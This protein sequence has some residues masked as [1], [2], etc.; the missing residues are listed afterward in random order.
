[1]TRFT[2]IRT[3]QQ[4]SLRVATVTAERLFKHMTNGRKPTPHEVYPDA[5]LQ[6]DS[7]GRLALR[8]H[9]GIAVLTV[10]G[11]TTA[12]LQEATKQAAMTLPTTV[13]AFAGAD[14]QSVVILVCYAVKEQQPADESV[15]TLLASAAYEQAVVTYSKAVGHPIR[16][17]T[18]TVRA[19]FTR[20][21][22]PTA[23]YNP[24]AIPLDISRYG[25]DTMRI[26]DLL[27]TRYRFRYNTVMG[28]TEYRLK[29]DSSDRW[30]PVD[31]RVLKSLTMAARLSGVDAW[32]NDIR[33]YVESSLIQ[34]YNPVQ[35]FLQRAKSCWD[36][37]TDHIGRLAATVPCELTQWPQ[38]FRKWLL[39]M[40]AQWLGKTRRYGNSVAPLLISGQG[41]NKSTFCR[42][43]LPEC[44]Q[45]GYN[46]NLL[47]SE[48]KQTLQAM[49]QFLLI[50]L[51]EFNQISQQM[52][53]GF[54]K[55]VIQLARVKI[56]R[57]YGRHV[58]DFPRLASFIATTNELSVLADPS[59][60]RRFIAVELTGPID[61]SQPI[62]YEGLYGQAVTLIERGEQYWFDDQ[63]VRQ[64]IAHNRQF[65]TLS[66]A[67][68]YF[69]E[70][71]TLP[72]DE[73]DGEWL[74]AAAIYDELRRRS[75]NGLRANGLKLFGRVLSNMEGLQ[76]RRVA[77]GTQY[78]VARRLP[79]P[80]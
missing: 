77:Y 30:C 79:M 61:L 70:C 60:N 53:E 69:H 75:G 54:L 55:N 18:A 12:E 43:L 78:F 31:D 21:A 8:R 7:D 41:Y 68:Q 44:L 66:P 35:Q 72:D 57:P 58:E 48:K 52:Q 28:Y 62:D 46:D 74:S 5:E 59:G 80:A 14:G 22:D 25:L 19:H 65:Q 38:W 27:T 15:A 9:N 16:Q 45:W 42:Q 64:I 76:R 20:P 1:M 2:L 63:E 36:G 37:T 4:G 40:V 29:A 67:E 33:R 56:K 71:F 24:D 47:I 23:A 50:N 34:P 13:A 32:D 26:I 51:D 11:L 39:Y 10:D 6:K 17:Q 49:S 73:Q 3:D